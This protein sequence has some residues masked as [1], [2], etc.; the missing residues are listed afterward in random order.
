MTNLDKVASI[1]SDLESSYSSS[2]GNLSRSEF[3]RKYLVNGD[4]QAINSLLTT[5]SADIVDESTSVKFS[6]L[7]KILL[8]LSNNYKY[9]PDEIPNLNSFVLAY[10]SSEQSDKDFD[11]LLD[12]ITFAQLLPAK[13]VPFSISTFGVDT[14]EVVGDYAITTQV[15]GRSNDVFIVKASTDLTSFESDGSVFQDK[16]K[17]FIGSKK[18]STPLIFINDIKSLSNKNYSPSQHGYTLS[19]NGVKSEVIML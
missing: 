6:S 10:I 17:K 12:M 8:S 4:S 18:L 11:S 19:N 13:K 2:G 15:E 14:V 5:I 9:I 1:W 16:I 7:Q 3:L